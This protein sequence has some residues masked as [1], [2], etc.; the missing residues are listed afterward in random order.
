VSFFYTKMDKAAKRI[1]GELGLHFSGSRDKDGFD[2][3]LFRPYLLMV[4]KDPKQKSVDRAY[5]VVQL[6]RMLEDTWRR[7]YAK[8]IDFSGQMAAPP[9]LLLKSR[10]AYETYNR[11]N[12]TKYV[13]VLSAGHYEPWDPRR[14]V[15]YKSDP[16]QERVVIFHEGTHMLFDH[17]NVAKSG[18]TASNQSMWFSEGIA[19]YFGGH[20]PSTEKDPV[21]GAPLWEPG[22]INDTRIDAMDVARK[23]KVLIPFES[24]VKT[25]RA[26]WG[27]RNEKERMWSQMIYAQGWALVY[28]LNHGE[29]GKYQKDFVEYMK[30]EINGKSGLETFK[31]VFGK[32]GMDQIAKGYDDFLAF[33]IKKH[34]EKKIVGGKIVD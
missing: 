4:E 28:F 8:E 12:E 26:E 31:E 27:A 9:I 18:D 24:L 23:M 19:E 5:E 22:R 1:E 3:V 14:M 6:L 2:P 32:H 29:N 30:L 33:I 16:E 21:T 13:P 17:K 25:T 15:I 34:K 20:G 10:E 11:R 7:R